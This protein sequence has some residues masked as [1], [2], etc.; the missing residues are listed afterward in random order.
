MKQTTAALAIVA[1]LLSLPS[2]AQPTASIPA[3]DLSTGK[4]RVFVLSDIGNEPDDQ[5][6]F[7]RLLVYSNEIDIEGLTAVTSTWLKN[8]TNPQT[9]RD[10]VGDYGNVRPILM[11]HADG[12]PTVN[13]LAARVH[14]GPTGYGI[15][16][17]HADAPSDGALALIA[18][19][20]RSDA[21]PL[22]VTVWGGVNTLAEALAY[23]RKTRTQAEQERFIAQLRVNSI[24][25]QDD[26][27]PWIRKEFPSLPR[28]AGA[29]ARRPAP[30]RSRGRSIN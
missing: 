23:I 6:S 12:W 3:A 10:I 22:W 17:I 4:P 5:M 11:K 16:A 21:R 27:G 29:D 15:A 14:S 8:T 25:D 30:A 1:A 28:R 9:M 19:A 18:A 26:A 2:S 24:S 13:Q 20:D 7:V